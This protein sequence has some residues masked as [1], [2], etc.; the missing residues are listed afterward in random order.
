[1]QYITMAAAASAYLLTEYF[2][3]SVDERINCVSKFKIWTMLCSE[4]NFTRLIAV[5]SAW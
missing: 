2:G 5:A 3:R 1:M 4:F